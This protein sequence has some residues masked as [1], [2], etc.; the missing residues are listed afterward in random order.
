M[1][2]ALLKGQDCKSICATGAFNNKRT[3]EFSCF[4]VKNDLKSKGHLSDKEMNS[5]AD[6][7]IQLAT[8]ISDGLLKGPDCKSICATVHTNKRT[9]E[10]GCFFVKRDLEEKGHLSEYA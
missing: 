6:F 7:E 8:S 3:C 9:C 5:G 2:D 1:S 4:F 10:F